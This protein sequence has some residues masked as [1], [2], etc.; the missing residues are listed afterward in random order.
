M[1][2]PFVCASAKDLITALNF[3]DPARLAQ[4]RLE[5]SARPLAYALGSGEAD[6]VALFAGLKPLLR[7]VLPSAELAGARARFERLGLAQGEATHRVSLPSTDG[8]VLFV[9]RDEQRVREALECEASAE[10]DL[11]LGRLLGYPRCC[12]EAYLQLSPPRHNVDAFHRAFAASRTFAPRLNCLDLSTFHFVSWLPCAFDCP[13]S[14]GYAD[15]V[16]NHIAARHGQFLGGARSAAPPLC[17]PGCRHE[18]FVAG[19]DE[20]LAAH[21]LLAFEEVQVSIAGALEEGGLRVERA[22]PS[23]R[24]RHPLAPLNEE[25]HEASARLAAL[26]AGSSRV[27]VRERT[28][29]ADGAPIFQ[30]T[31]AQLFPFGAAPHERS[32]A[33]GRRQ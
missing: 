17:P 1:P 13:T 12:V 24:D 23:A 8:T 15:A 29:F 10:H 5:A 19:V 31:A 3:V 4:A 2:A 11:E 27:E 28:L 30:A 21:R 16:A 33:E 18:R 26:V 7:Q 32:R 6:E 22:W 20:A 25:A 9:G 14:R